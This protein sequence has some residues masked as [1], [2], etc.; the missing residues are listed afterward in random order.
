VKIAII[1]GTGK[2]GL[3]FVSRLQRTAHEC[4]IG[5]RDHAKAQAAAA[6][7]APP[8][9]AFTNTDAA[10]WCELAMLTIPYAAHRTLI[11]PLRE[12][13]RGKIVIDAT[14]PLNPQN[15]FRL[16][17]ES[18]TS[19]AEETSALLAEAQ[20]FGGFHTLSHRILRQ[21]EHSEDVLIAGPSQRKPDV[22]QFIRDM[23]LHPVDAGPIEA[24]RLLESMTALLISINRQNKVKES[25]LKITGI[26]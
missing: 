7:L 9:H 2:L 1:G 25:G 6:S 12:D 5:S 13:L 16:G 15:L 23:N 21:A 18:G 8:P 19:A 10:A 24:A 26:P 14:V 11:E 4:A 20:V 17:S 22:M 3:G